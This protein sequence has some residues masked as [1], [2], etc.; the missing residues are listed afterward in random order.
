MRLNTE[1]TD[2]EPVEGDMPA[3]EATCHGCAFNQE[4]EDFI[5]GCGTH[6]CTAESFPE[7][8]PLSG[9]ANA[10]VWVKKQ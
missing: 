3:A 4:T 8:H 5:R 9:A 1:H 10:I 6:A 7:S 2:Y